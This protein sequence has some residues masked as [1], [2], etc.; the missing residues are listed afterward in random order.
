MS[1]STRASL[2]H[3]ASLAVQSIG[4][5]LSGSLVALVAVSKG[6]R[7][8]RLIAVAILAGVLVAV[9]GLSLFMRV[10]RRRDTCRQVLRMLRGYEFGGVL[11]LAVAALAAGLMTLM[12]LG[13]FD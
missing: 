1:N 12:H 4:W 9:S 13:V 11:V 8:E 7:E 3:A 10:A 6:A 2:T 5:L